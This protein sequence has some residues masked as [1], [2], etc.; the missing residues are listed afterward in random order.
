MPPLFSHVAQRISLLAFLL[1]SLL[2]GPFLFAQS[3]ETKHSFITADSSKQR[4]AWI[5]ESGAIQWEYKIGP[6]H[7]L[8]CLSSGN[9]LFQTNWTQ[10]VEVN[11]K[12]NEVVWKYDAAQRNGN[13]GK[14]VEVHAF[15]RLENGNTMI[16]ESGVSRIIEVTPDGDLEVEIRLDVEEPHPHRDTRLARKLANGNYLVCHEGQG[17][18]KEYD[19]EGAVVWSYDVPLFGRQPAGGHGLEAFG[20]QCFSAVR[21]KNGNTLIATGNGHSVIEVTPAHEVVWK[22]TQDELEGIQL[23]WVTTLQVLPNGNIVLGNCHAGQK[24]PQIVEVTRDKQV[25]WKFQDFGRFGNATT[26]THILTTNG[27]PVAAKLGQQR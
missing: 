19:R 6:L 12:T 5:D 4:I 20:N 23:A 2:A 7:D 11:P 9:I 25:V 10:L 26:N 27:Q 3:T 15:Q 22:L 17:Q 13:L 16:V 24:N 18:V 1:G 14:K 21:M 8:H